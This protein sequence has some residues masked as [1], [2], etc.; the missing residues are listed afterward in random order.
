MLLDRILDNL[1]SPTSFALQATRTLD[2]LDLHWPDLHRRALRATTRTG[3]PVGILLP[4][5]QRLRHG[6]ILH[7]DDHHLITINLLPTELL[8][9]TPPSARHAALIAFELGNLHLPVEITD[10]EIVTLPDGPALAVCRQ[11]EVPHR[12]ET[13]RFHPLR[14]SVL[15]NPRLA[16][17]FRIDRT[18]TADR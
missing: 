7:A 17:D 6:D 2:P 13:R 15:N 11:H 5:G 18:P 9:A 8:I 12:L 4:L 3:R 14:S 1:F 16:L 10:H